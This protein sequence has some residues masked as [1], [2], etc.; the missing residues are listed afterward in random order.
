MRFDVEKAQIE[1]R[2]GACAIIS[3]NLLF[4]TDRWI[5][6]PEYR[7]FNFPVRGNKL[8]IPHFETLSASIVDNMT[9]KIRKFSGVT[10]R[11]I[12]DFTGMLLICVF[13][14]LEVHDTV[15]VGLAGLGPLSIEFSIE[16]AKKY[17]STNRTKRIVFVDL[18]QGSDDLKLTLL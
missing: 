8:I 6:S 7:C 13:S 9:R 10:L 12:N 17:L 18:S 16:L 2:G 15:I 1:I 14:E 11:T 4:V 5:N 3:C